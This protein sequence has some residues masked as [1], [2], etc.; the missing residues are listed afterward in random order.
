[1]DVVDKIAPG[2]PPAAPTK[3]VHASLGDG[4]AP[5]AAAVPPAA[6]APAPAPAQGSTP[7]N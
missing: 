6:Q 1:M 4:S 7:G 2:E 3:I 5:A